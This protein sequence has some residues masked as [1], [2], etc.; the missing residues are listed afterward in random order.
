MYTSF[1]T[2]LDDT[3]GSGMRVQSELGDRA[4]GAAMRLATIATNKPLYFGQLRREAQASMRFYR[5]HHAL[6]TCRGLVPP[7]AS[8]G[9]T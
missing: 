6:E 2:T 1:I 5:S 8:Q 7:M 4:V 9:M 3:Q